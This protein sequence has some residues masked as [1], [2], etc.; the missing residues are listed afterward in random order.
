MK[1]DGVYKEGMTYAQAFTHR[2]PSMVAKHFGTD[3]KPVYQCMNFV[4]AIITEY[5]HFYELELNV[6]SARADKLKE[7]K[8]I[9]PDPSYTGTWQDFHGGAEND[10]TGKG[11]WG[12]FSNYIMAWEAY[13]NNTMFQDISWDNLQAGDIIATQYSGGGYHAQ[14][15]EKIET[16]TVTTGFWFWKT[17]KQ[18]TFITITQGSLDNSTDGSEIYRKEYKL[19]DIK[20]GRFGSVNKGEKGIK[21]RRLNYE[22]ISTK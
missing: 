1:A 10:N 14:I 2:V 16:R 6:R 22:N 19:S 21:A 20:Q 7:R 17:T 18:E 3:P 12:T 15:V 11:K 4:T 13:N 8:K 5:A 9:A